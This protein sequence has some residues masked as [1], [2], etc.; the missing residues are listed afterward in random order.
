MGA[1]NHV[2]VMPDADKEYARSILRASYGAA[3]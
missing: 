2:I 3:G 1:K